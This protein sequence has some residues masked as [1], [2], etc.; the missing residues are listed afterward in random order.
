MLHDGKEFNTGQFAY[1]NIANEA[2]KESYHTANRKLPN[3]VG[4]FKFQVSEN[5]RKTEG[6]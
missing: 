1:T 3:H 5:D 6:A 2:N 4:Y